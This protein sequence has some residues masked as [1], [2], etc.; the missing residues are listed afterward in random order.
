MFVNVLRVLSCLLLLFQVAHTAIIPIRQYNSEDQDDSTN[1]DTGS[2]TGEPSLTLMTP[3]AS[4]TP[5]TSL[6]SGGDFAGNTEIIIPHYIY[7][8]EGAWTPLE[9]L[10]TNNTNVKFT[11]IINP[12]SGP[13]GDTLPDAN[14]RKVIPKLTAHSNVAVIGY[15]S[16]CYGGRPM[17]AVQH[18]IATYANWP[19]VSGDASFAVHGIFLDE[20]AAEPDDK[21]VTF[22]KQITSLIKENKGFGPRNNVVMNPGTIPDNAY[23]DIPD[24]TVIFESPHSKFQ[25]ALAGH[26]FERIKNMDKARLSS[27]VTSVPTGTDLAGLIA[28]LRE[29]TG[30]IYL[31]NS[32]GYLEYSQ[33]LEEAARIIGSS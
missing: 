22:Y 7:P 3:S 20:A 10:V 4:A 6:Q 15:V 5:T 23:L 29:I 24:S 30:H 27:M 2:Q 32:A 31:S 9:Q 11:I 26:E 25:E 16:T 12:S 28:Q 14:W 33:A 17:S 1:P 21:K 13:G 19:T 18:D 8:A